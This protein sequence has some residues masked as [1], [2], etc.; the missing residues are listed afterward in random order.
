VLVANT[1]VVGLAL[2]STKIVLTLLE[3]GSGGAD[4]AHRLED[5]LLHSRRSRIRDWSG[6]GENNRSEAT[7][8]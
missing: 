2:C 1:A 5:G 4:P 6:S 3:V 7:A 8:S